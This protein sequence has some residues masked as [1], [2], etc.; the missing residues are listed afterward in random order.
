MC[1][2]RCCSDQLVEHRRGD[3]HG[4]PR[5]GDL[6]DHR[7][8]RPD[9]AIRRPPHSVL[10]DDPMVISGAELLFPP[11]GRPAGRRRAVQRDLA[12]RRRRS[13]AGWWV[14]GTARRSRCA[15]RRSCTG[16][17]VLEVRHQV[18]QPGQASARR[19]RWCPGPS[20]RRRTP[21][22]RHGRARGRW[23]PAR[24][25][26]VG[27]S[28]STRSPGMVSAA[29]TPAMA[30]LGPAGDQDLVAGGGQPTLGEPAAT[31]SRSESSP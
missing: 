24:W 14:R 6:L 16:R 9:P 13:A 3:V 27:C 5:A 25:D 31:T 23:R 11:P 8:P 29:N 2:I 7:P 17:W 26:K 12:H 10:L 20:R 21:P 19:P 15:A 18:D 30:L 22:A 4:G 1:C 28:T